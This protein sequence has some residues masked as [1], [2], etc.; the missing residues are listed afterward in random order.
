MKV[1]VIGSG[2]REH[3]LTWKLAQSPRVTATAAC[4]GL[5]PVANAFGAVSSMT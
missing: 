1:L 5:R 4:F 3:T 2:G